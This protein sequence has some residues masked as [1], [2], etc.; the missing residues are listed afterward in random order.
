M[1][2]ICA[3]HGCD[4][5]DCW[6]WPDSVLFVAS[7]RTTRSMP[8]AISTKALSRLRQ[9]ATGFPLVGSILSMANGAP[10][11][12]TG[13]SRTG[14]TRALPVALHRSRHFH[15]IAILRGH[16][17][18]TDQQENYVGALEVYVN[19]LLPVLTGANLSY[20]PR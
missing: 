16:K 2:C 17:G 14:M 11:K 15:T 19:L 5:G 20:M 9:F 18:G 4:G 10:V 13:R 3:P 12:S 7:S 6:P 8:S 1:G